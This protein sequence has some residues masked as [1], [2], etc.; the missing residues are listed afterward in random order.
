MADASNLLDVPQET[1]DLFVAPPQ[2]KDQSKDQAQNLNSSFNSSGRLSLVQ[3]QSEGPASAAKKKHNFRPSVPYGSGEAPMM[4]TR[5]P[6]FFPGCTMP[7]TQLEHRN[8]ERIHS[9]WGSCTP[10]VL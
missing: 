6:P 5:L 10:R 8:L 3:R 2:K 9:D 4:S 7:R 1:K